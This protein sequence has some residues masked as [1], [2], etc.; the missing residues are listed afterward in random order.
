MDPIN[1]GLVFWEEDSTNPEANP[2]DITMPENDKK[3][4]TAEDKEESTPE[5]VEKTESTET[6][7]D[8]EATTEDEDDLDLSDLFADLEDASASN[9][10]SQKILDDAAAAGGLYHLFKLKNLK[11]NSQSK[12]ILIQNLVGK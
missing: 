4:D 6:Q 7:K 10:E 2:S 5:V 1:D 3:E 12:K 11:L 9:E 8:S